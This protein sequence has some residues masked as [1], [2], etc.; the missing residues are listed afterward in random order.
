[1]ISTQK[2][3][4]EQLLR[5]LVEGLLDG[6]FVKRLSFS[7]FYQQRDTVSAYYYINTDNEGDY[8]DKGFLEK[9]PFYAL[10]SLFKGYKWV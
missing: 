4:Q 2:F 6:E 1:M 5:M 8:Y 9:E 7:T 3:E 10:P